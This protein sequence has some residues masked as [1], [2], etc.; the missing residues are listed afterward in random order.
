VF[1]K[2]LLSLSSRFIIKVPFAPLFS[3]HLILIYLTTRKTFGEQVH[4]SLFPVLFYPL[5]LTPNIFPSNLHTLN[6]C[7]SVN[8]TDQVADPLTPTG[9]FTVLK[10]FK[11]NPDSVVSSEQTGC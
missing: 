7:S 8:V 2:T 9:K 10:Y 5:P 6:L 1:P 3:A 4:V 11:H